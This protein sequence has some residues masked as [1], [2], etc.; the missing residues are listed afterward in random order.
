MNKMIVANLVHRPV[1]SVISILAVAIEVTMI[2]LMV[3]LMLGILN[4][5]KD[6][7]RGLGADVIVRPPG[8]ANFGAFSSAP[9]SLHYADVIMKQPHVAAVAP[10]VLQTTT[11]LTNI[12]VLN[13]IDLPSFEAVG[14]PLIYL[15]GGP[16]QQPY[17]MIVDDVYAS[18]NKVG[19]GSKISVLNHEFK[20][21]GI[22]PHGR[23][24]R[25]YVPMKTMQELIG[26]EN[27]ASVFYVKVD[28]PK[29][30]DAA[31][32]EFK[33]ILPNFV[34]TSTREWMQL[35]TPDNIPG[36][37]TVI[38]VV[39]GIAVVI[40]FIVIFQSMYTAVMERTREIGIL[41]SLGASKS[42]VVRVILRET[43]LLAV[44]G[45]LAGFLMSIAGRAGLVHR[46]PTLTVL[47]I[48]WK[49]ATYATVIAIGGAMLGAVYP[50]FK[51]AQ[52]DP[53]DAL[54]YE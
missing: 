9:A 10:V 15:K 45:I 4:D 42:Y 37:S 51:A 12:E 11:S 28:D 38:K 34:I 44:A 18:A 8:S 33:S 6:R 43:L 23:G 1:R 35:M 30:T 29:N 52:K 21:S 47:P 50:A 32:D 14:G 39:I 5:S 17:D 54:A 7:Q 20:V 26:A 2:L 24:A 22:V 19:V 16:F 48:T 53:I 46:F 40:G 31:V 36:L 13:G 49:W 3:G 41:K 27:K 25:R